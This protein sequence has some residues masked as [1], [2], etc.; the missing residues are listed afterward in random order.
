MP[1]LR[2]ACY[3]RVSTERQVEK[4][5]PAAQRRALADHCERQGW[6]IVGWYEDLG[7]SG[8]TLDHRPGALRLLEDVR[9]GV[10][11]LVLMVEF[12]RLSRGSGADWDRILAALDEGGAKLATPS[13]I[14]DPRCVE[15]AFLQDLF[16]ALARR[17]RRKTAER[18]ARGRR[19]SVRAGEWNGAPPYGYRIEKR[20]LVPVEAQATV[21]R[22]VFQMAT[23]GVSLMGIAAALTHDGI[24]TSTGRPI[25]FAGQ[26]RRIVVNAAYTGAIVFVGSRR[27]GSA[28][29]IV[30]DGAHPA[31]VPA[32]EFHRANAMIE[33]RARAG[34]PQSRWNSSYVLVGLLPCPRCGARMNGSTSRNRRRPWENTFRRYYMCMGAKYGRRPKGDQC[35]RYRADRVEEGVLADVAAALTCPS[36]LESVRR[37]LVEEKV[38]GNT[39]DA[40]R[41]AQLEG[42]IADAER[43]VRV[44]YED[45]VA[46]RITPTQFE[47]WNRE[48][49][50][51]QVTARVALRT[52]E[53]RLLAL[54]RH[55]D[56]EAVV[57]QLSDMGRA[58]R[59][60]ESAELKRLLG[61]V[62]REVRVL[63]KRDDGS[64]RVEVVYRLPGLGNTASA[65]PPGLV[66]QAQ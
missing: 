61:E 43:R 6:K 17:E 47:A 18:S 27:G 14:L 33:A 36:V 29:T 51:R 35:P 50:D 26:V 7:I 56:I 54:G 45:R 9:R 2:V 15:D 10:A 44:L 58:L 65:A 46:E 4:W 66:R 64:F 28:E 25:W 11:D 40:A 3:S 38:R 22:R 57:A 20:R 13:Q 59:R 41:R 1:E 60:L 39:A 31:I 8:K 37:Q 48:Q 21:V 5:S 52:I 30:V 53:D 34:L 24:P 23:A 12:E 49:L 62:V 16:A 19:E 32:H 55:V 42:E 63:E